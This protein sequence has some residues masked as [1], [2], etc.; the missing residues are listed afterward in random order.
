MPAGPVLPALSGA[1]LAERDVPVML[2]ANAPLFTRLADTLRGR[3]Q[4]QVQVSWDEAAAPARFGDPAGLDAVREGLS[5]RIGDM[6]GLVSEEMVA[7]PIRDAVIFNAALL[8]AENEIP[9]LDQTV[10]AVDAIWTDGFSIRQIG[11]SPA[12]SF[13]SLGLRQVSSRAIQKARDRLGLSGDLDAEAIR[14]ARRHAL[15]S[16]KDDVRERV[17]TAA[18]ILE[19]LTACP[20][21]EKG[22]HH[23]FVWWEGR[24]GPKTEE[25][26][27]A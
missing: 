26:A 13:C 23:A 20:E 19:V 8:V 15:M 5:A 21:A 24:A 25:R 11:P 7:L 6:L 10:E 1:I 27:A 2:Q 14:S 22:F 12:V 17:K 18:D 16:A 3:V 4:Y 9:A